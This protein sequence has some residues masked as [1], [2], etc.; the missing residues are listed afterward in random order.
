MDFYRSMGNTIRARRNELGLSLEILGLRAGG[1]TRATISGIE[2]G[3]QRLSAYQLHL[4]AKVL[5]MTT[6]D[7]IQKALAQEISSIQFVKKGKRD[8]TAINNL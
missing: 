5:D 3:R 7:L 8:E 1:L 4:F 6:D 2:K